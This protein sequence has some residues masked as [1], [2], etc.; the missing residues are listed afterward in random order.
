[1]GAADGACCAMCAA[2]QCR[3]SE[4]SHA[5]I[6]DVAVNLSV[7][8]AHVSNHAKFDQGLGSRWFGK[9]QLLTDLAAFFCSIAVNEQV[10]SQHAQTSRDLRSA[11]SYQ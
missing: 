9:R 4:S 7:T 6:A 8:D 3:S 11:A 1:M 10:Q 5:I 2:L